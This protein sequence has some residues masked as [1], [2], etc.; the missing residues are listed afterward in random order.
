MQHGPPIEIDLNG[1]EIDGDYAV[2]A[3]RAARLY[4]AVFARIPESD[5][6]AIRGACDKVIPFAGGRGDTYARYGGFSPAKRVIEVDVKVFDHLSNEAFSGL[7]AHEL[8]HACDCARR[9]IRRRN[10]ADKETSE[11]NANEIARSW[12]FGA[13]L[14][15]LE[16]ESR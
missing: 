5:R 7:L 8:A 11:R 6:H 14:D 10:K 16:S 4:E 1:A 13:E 9:G 3:E 2:S 12:G 15:R